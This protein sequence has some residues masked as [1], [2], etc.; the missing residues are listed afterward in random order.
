MI[1]FWGAWP[2]MI[3][4]KESAGRGEQTKKESHWKKCQERELSDLKG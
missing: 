2:F 1:D 4:A 3:Q